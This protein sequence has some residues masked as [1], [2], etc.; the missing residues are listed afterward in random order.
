[1]IILLHLIFEEKYVILYFLLSNSLLVLS[2]SITLK[3]SLHLLY[4]YPI[5][6]KLKEILT[7][8][9]V[10]FDSYEQDLTYSQQLHNLGLLQIILPDSS[11]SELAKKITDGINLPETLSSSFHIL[12]STEPVPPGYVMVTCMVICSQVLGRVYKCGNGSVWGDGEQLQS[13]RKS[14]T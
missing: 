5:Y 2:S 6:S 8:I 10:A 9:Q 13:W 12:L 3:S 4:F 7:L 14:F 1:M 11:Q